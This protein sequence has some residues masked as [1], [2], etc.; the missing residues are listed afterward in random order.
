M[1]LFSDE[2]RQESASTRI[3]RLFGF[4]GETTSGD[5]LPVGARKNV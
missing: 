3:E 5:A 1:L 2:K 4:G